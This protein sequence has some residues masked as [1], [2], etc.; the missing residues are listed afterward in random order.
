MLEHI[1]IVPFGEPD[2]TQA[3]LIVS[4]AP[5][6]ASNSEVLRIIL[7]A[8]AE[9]AAESMKKQR[10]ERVAV[11]RHSM[12]FKRDE[13]EVV[14]GRVEQ[15]DPP[16]VLGLLVDLTDVVSHVRTANAH[17]D[18]FRVWQDI[19]RT[20]A[21]LFAASAIV[22]D[23]GSNRALVLVHG[24]VGPDIELVIHHISATLA[25]YF[26]E[27]GGVSAPRHSVLSYPDDTD[28]VSSLVSALVQ[29]K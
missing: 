27:I 2:G 17:V 13:L 22:A 12:A 16:N 3:L 7:A 10:M 11:M 28:S 8:V 25:D 4:Q 24:N 6:L 26:P 21:A 9:S 19:L 29:K 15:R 14:A 5:L 1:L 20:V 23:A 18:S